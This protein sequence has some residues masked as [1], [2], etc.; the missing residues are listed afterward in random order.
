M[1]SR[2]LWSCYCLQGP[3]PTT[4]DQ[5]PAA[6]FDPLIDVSDDDESDG[7]DMPSWTPP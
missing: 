3:A 7:D 6:M 5:L 4:V 2:Y 1:S